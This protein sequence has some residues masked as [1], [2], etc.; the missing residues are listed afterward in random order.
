MFYQVIILYQK[1]NFTK[2][3]FTG[4]E[5]ISLRYLPNM[6]K[7][8]AKARKHK[9][10]PK[11]T[12]DSDATLSDM[13]DDAVPSMD[14]ISRPVN[15]NK[16]KSKSKSKSKSKKKSSK[17]NVA[18]T[19]SKSKTVS[20]NK[21]KNKSKRKSSKK[22]VTSTASKSN[23]KKTSTTKKQ[24][25]PQRPSRS[26][27]TNKRDKKGSKNKLS[28]KNTNEDS[29]NEGDDEASNRNRSKSYDIKSLDDYFYP[30]LDESDSKYNNNNSNE[31]CK[32]IIYVFITF[33]TQPCI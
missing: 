6:S 26:A 12:H 8:T 32:Y 4:S 3:T 16:K 18:S 30:N 13:E 7:K 17:K 27:S 11:S 14:A 15:V 10:K 1:C 24:A 2:T 9:G 19:A 20:K 25:L 21:S 28:T 33:N 23:V 31:L 5:I 22:N 29:G